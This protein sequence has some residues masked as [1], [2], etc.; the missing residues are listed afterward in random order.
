MVKSVVA[1][2][3]WLN[4]MPCCL[5]CSIQPDAGQEKDGGKIIRVMGSIGTAAKNGVV[6]VTVVR[7]TVLKSD[8]FFSTYQ[9]GE[10]VRDPKT[11][12]TVKLPGQYVA[13]S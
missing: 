11:K 7:L 12:E 2:A 13:V 5:P 10:T 3:S 4:R 6:T 8:R 9:D 1:T